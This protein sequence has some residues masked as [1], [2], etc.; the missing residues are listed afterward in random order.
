MV[1]LLLFQE[2]EVQTKVL[3]S[4]EKINPCCLSHLVYDI[5]L[6]QTKPTRT[7]YS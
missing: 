2:G 6:W 3:Q 5:L 7:L 4:S 1:G